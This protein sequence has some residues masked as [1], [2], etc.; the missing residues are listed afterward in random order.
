M[1]EK[2]KIVRTGEFAAFRVPFVLFLPPSR[3]TCLPV[4]SFPSC[5]HSTPASFRAA[6]SSVARLP[7]LLVFFPAVCVDLM[8]S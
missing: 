1:R 2:K 7:A 4:C 6:H 3:T 8:S 5:L